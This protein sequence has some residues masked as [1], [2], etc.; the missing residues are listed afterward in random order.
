MQKGH[1]QKAGREETEE[2]GRERRNRK[3]KLD[4]KEYAGEI[5]R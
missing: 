1:K 3:N 4:Q 5:Q 2:T